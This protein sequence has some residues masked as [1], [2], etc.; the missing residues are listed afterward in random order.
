M[1]RKYLWNYIERKKKQMATKIDSSSPLGQNT[2]LTEKV[3]KE[4]QLD[5]FIHLDIS[6]G[7]FLTGVTLTV[8][9]IIYLFKQNTEYISWIFGLLLFILLPV[10]WLGNFLKSTNS[11]YKWYVGL[12]LFFGIILNFVAVLMLLLYNTRINDLKKD[13]KANQVLSP[14]EKLK[15]YPVNSRVIEFS[16]KI[17]I[18]FTTNLV[19]CIAIIMNFFVYEGETTKDK[20][21][22]PS[23]AKNMYWWYDLI[24]RNIVMVD[25]WITY[26]IQFIPING[27]LKMFLLFSGGFLFFFFSFFV[28]L[29]TTYVDDQISD[30]YV[31]KLISEF[32]YGLQGI[33][34]ATSYDIVNFPNILVET[35]GPVDF[36]ALS[37][38]FL[39]STFM[40]I[41]WFF[42][43]LIPKQK[44]LDL[45][46]PGIS[47]GV[48]TGI[49]VITYIILAILIIIFC[50]QAA[51]SYIL[52]ATIF[53]FLL[54]TNSVNLISLGIFFTVNYLIL[55]YGN[56]NYIKTKGDIS[57]KNET[58]QNYILFCLCFLF[59]ILG[60]PVVFMVFELFGRILGF[61]LAGDL[62]SYLFP[63][64]TTNKC[65]GIKLLDCPNRVLFST[66]LLI[67]SFLG[68]L[69]G[70]Y[71]YGIS[72]KA[73]PWMSNN[74]NNPQ[75]KIFVI[76]I[77]SIMVGWF[78]AL[79]FKF[80]MI[81]F[82]YESAIQSLR[83]ILFILAP[84]T[85][86]GLAITQIVLADI[87][88]KMIGNPTKT[89][90]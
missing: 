85:V 36:A 72:K 63:N 47:S 6:T 88:S 13:Y 60:T 21:N 77:M 65:E 80:N 2:I 69:F 16:N 29:K 56:I 3:G 83:T 87:S 38:F 43:L 54:V 15:E 24:H 82:I 61:S 9:C 55:Y 7:S 27:F 90:G 41:I 12:S 67:S 20:P 44:P 52:F 66:F 30:P 34:P 37:S 25:Q 68:L 57:S 50:G 23:M 48:M 70:I 81:S 79:H 53:L 4:S 10:T 51:L 33:Y 75:I 84:L 45:N 89:D 71:N 18:L 1:V 64:S 40:F 11:K 5:N 35:A 31:Q 76:T 32:G 42:S 74:G 39:S 59:S 28:K 17:K 78:F 26:V 46:K 86:L 8:I 14:G 22:T 49:V 58:S 62:K 73:G 19:L